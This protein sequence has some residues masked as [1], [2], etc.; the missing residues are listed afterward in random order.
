MALGLGVLMR[1]Y[2]D[3]YSASL[4]LVIY[5]LHF[6]VI[7]ES[8]NSS[9]AEGEN[10]TRRPRNGPQ[11]IVLSGKSRSA[12]KQRISQFEGYLARSSQERR[13]VAYTMC[14]RREHL[15]YRAFAVAEGQ[16]SISFSGIEESF[17][18]SPRLAFVFTG[19]GAQWAGMA[20][21]L[22]LFSEC[23]RDTIN[24]LDRTL[25]CLPGPPEW[26][27]AGMFFSPDLGV[28]S[29]LMLLIKV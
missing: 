8:S 14:Q 6:Q 10:P 2:V 15:K 21:D 18:S 16:G 7:M 19:Q 25:Q 12:L 17:P 4:Y 28:L 3:Y 26:K 13:D 11:L 9:S 24:E 1:M 29:R 23:F 20:N 5:S 22:L 27:I